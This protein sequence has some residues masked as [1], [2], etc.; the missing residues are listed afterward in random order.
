MII[1]V[2]GGKW[3]RQTAASSTTKGKGGA[4]RLDRVSTC[5]FEDA[6]LR[7]WPL[8][9][10]PLLDVREYRRFHAFLTNSRFHFCV[11]CRKQQPMGNN[12]SEKDLRHYCYISGIHDTTI[13][14]GK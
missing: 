11:R 5:V 6:P 12:K 4:E 7:Q 9:T 8:E 3:E 1:L 14:G 13:S 2:G 10:I